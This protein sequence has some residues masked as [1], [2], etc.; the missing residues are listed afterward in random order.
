MYIYGPHN[1][2]V[3]QSSKF[4]NYWTQIF[5]EQG[6]M[7]RKTEDRILAMTLNKKLKCKCPRERSRSRWNNWLENCYAEGQT[8]RKNSYEG[9]Q[10][11]GETWLL[12]VLNV[13]EETEEEEL[14]HFINIL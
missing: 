3:I 5:K 12:N 14:L 6:K 9:T 7:E 11:D 10:T 1:Y 4:G 13:Q 8:W 2:L